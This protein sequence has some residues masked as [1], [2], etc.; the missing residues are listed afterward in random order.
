MSQTTKSRAAIAEVITPR[1]HLISPEQVETDYGIA[2]QTQAVWRCT[3]RYG[4]RNLTIK[5]GRKVVYRRT[6]IEAW[7]E[8]R[9]G[10]QGES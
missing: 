9:R 4:W 8:S 2:E 1:S 6:D 3:N 7:L 10:L 5:L